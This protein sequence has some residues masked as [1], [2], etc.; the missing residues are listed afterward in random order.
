MMKKFIV[1]ALCALSLCAASAVALNGET[2]P[3]VSSGYGFVI[4]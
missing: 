1:A 3:V 4:R 2:T